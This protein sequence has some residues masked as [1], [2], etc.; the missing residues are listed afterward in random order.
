MVAGSEL[1]APGQIVGGYTVLSLLVQRDGLDIYAAEETTGG[2][3]AVL[4]C[5]AGGAQ[6]LDE[7]GLFELIERLVRFRNPHVPG[8][9]AAGTHSGVVWIAGERIEGTPLGEVLR[10]RETIGLGVALS[11]VQTLLDVLMAAERRGVRHG[12][13]SSSNIVLCPTLPELRVLQLG[14]EQAFGRNVRATADVWGAAALLYEMLTGSPPEDPFTP[15]S[16]VLRFVPRSL[17]A[18]LDRALQSDP[19]ARYQSL[20]DLV[21]ALKEVEREPVVQREIE[22]A[23]E[24]SETVFGVKLAE[25]GDGDENEKRHRPKVRARPRALE[26]SGRA[27]RE[28]PPVGAPVAPSDRPPL[29]TVV[30]ERVGKELA[31]VVEEA[32]FGEFLF[33]LIYFGM[34]RVPLDSEAAPSGD[35]DELA[36]AGGPADEPP[37][38]VAPPPAPEPVIQLPSRDVAQPPAPDP[39]IQPPSRAPST[40]TG[41]STLRSRLPRPP[42]QAERSERG[43]RG[44]GRVRRGIKRLCLG[45]A[46]V[47]GGVSALLLLREVPLL[48]VEPKQ[49]LCVELGRTASLPLPDV[50]PA[51]PPLPPPPP[52]AAPLSPARPNPASIPARRKP[53]PPPKF[54]DP[55]RAKTYKLDKDGTEHSRSQ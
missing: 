45:L 53:Q 26:R 52:T 34:I 25:D 14:I 55:V 17:C 11:H 28:M 33:T 31:E 32:V 49:A 30:G 54:D 10:A 48:K 50:A 20:R 40:P 21:R 2:N 9:F 42:A 1:L 47:A 19:R 35:H 8:T 27:R 39:G 5:R 37:R 4:Q 7:A 29:R 3:Q 51:A 15:I 22:Q 6:G 13:L 24:R 44:E 23:V 43:E 38:D 46:A 18:V 41:P 12:A 36:A 16:R